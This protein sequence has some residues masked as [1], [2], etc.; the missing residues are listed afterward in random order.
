M[1]KIIIRPQK[2][3]YTI[4][5]SIIFF[6]LIKPD[7]LEHLGFNWLANILIGVDIVLILVLSTLML[8][9]KFKMSKMTGL[10]FLFFVFRIYCNCVIFE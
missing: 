10:I 6:A 4:I 8:R 7:S 1:K 9:G 2:I 5:Y 3:I